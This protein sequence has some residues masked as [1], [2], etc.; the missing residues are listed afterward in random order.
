MLTL[1]LALGGCSPA[2]T[3]AIRETDA[4]TTD[5]DPGGTDPG[6]TDPGD[7]DASDTGPERSCTALGGDMVLI[8]VGAYFFGKTNIPSEITQPYCIDRTEVT[9]ADWN[10]CVEAGGCVGYE[11]WDACKTDPPSATAPNQCFPDRDTYPANWIDWERA[12]A[13]CTWAGKRLPMP[14]E[15]LR[16]ARGTD[17]RT[18]PWGND[19]TCSKAHLE[20]GPV[21]NTC[22]DASGFP[23][24]PVPVGSYPDGASPAG[25]FDM[26][27]NL[28]EWVEYREDPTIPPVQGEYAI[29]MGGSYFDGS[30]YGRV[31]AADGMIGVGIT[32]RQH[33]FR[34]VGAP[35]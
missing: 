14:Y 8:P 33:G 12:L 18:Y 23:D 15:W 20:R 28:K 9:A 30:E 2:D 22:H 10:R 5:S 27:G 6:D 25:L 34:C 3:D 4:Q 31:Y 32:S 35:Q 19:F 24:A 1:L 21:F 17:Q 13:Y 29:A 16:A 7:S 26:A 11:A